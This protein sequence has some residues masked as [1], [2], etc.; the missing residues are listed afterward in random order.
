VDQGVS[1]CGHVSETVIDQEG[2]PAELILV[3][4]APFSKPVSGSDCPHPLYILKRRLLFLKSKYLKTIPLPLEDS[5]IMWYYL[6]ERKGDSG[7]EEFQLLNY[8]ES[9]MGFGNSWIYCRYL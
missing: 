9:K 5:L 4:G 1:I 7:H 2:S 3:G 8:R 6:R